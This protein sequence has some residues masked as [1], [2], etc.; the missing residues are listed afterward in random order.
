MPSGNATQPSLRL[1]RQLL[2]EFAKSAQTIKAFEDLFDQVSTGL[3]GNIDDLFIVTQLLTDN[4]IDASD[5]NKQILINIMDDTTPDAESSLA[6]NVFVVDEP[7][8]QTS[9]IPSDIQLLTLSAS[10]FVFNPAVNGDL[11]VSGGTLTSISITRRGVAV[12]VANAS[13]VPCSNGDA[14]QINY[15]VAPTVN[16]IPRA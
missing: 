7:L 5:A 1:N 15:T 14:I 8:A 11:T 4:E 10:P 12:S 2:S 3:P 13:F 16:F 9:N 6:L